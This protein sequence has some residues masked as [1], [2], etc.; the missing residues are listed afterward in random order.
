MFSIIRNRLNNF[1]QRQS[2]GMPIGP[3][4]PKMQE[5]VECKNC[6]THFS[7]AY[8]PQCGQPALTKRIT[9]RDTMHNIFIA[10]LAGDNIFFRTCCDLMWRPGYLVYDYLCG[11]RARYFRPVQ[12]LVR[13][14]AIFVLLSL[15]I[16][17]G[18][19]AIHIDDDILQAN[20]HSPT[21][22]SMIHGLTGLLSNKVISSLVAAFILVLPFKMAYCRQRIQRPDG[23]C[24]TLN[25]AEHFY[26]L[27]YLNCQIMIF[28]YICLVL[29]KID[30]LTECV[31]NIDFWLVV[32]LPI[33]LYRQ[34]YDISWV[35]SILLTL[36]A[37]LAAILLLCLVLI[38]GFGIF[39]GIDA[40]A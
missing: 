11:R 15:F 40:V 35:K 4:L 22:I 26:A 31:R 25:I 23:S 6:G 27:V 18:D 20:V 2:E 28:S 38:L 19:S 8:C 32:L 39:Y 5:D 30:T 9:L 37:L 36:V 33:W 21:L 3:H 16:D 13:M 17:N 12:M 1:R 34:L 10:F 29:G 24:S 7:G 14:V